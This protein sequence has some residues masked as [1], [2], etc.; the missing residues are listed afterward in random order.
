MQYF[1]WFDSREKNNCVL[2]GLAGEKLSGETYQGMPLAAERKRAYRFLMDDDYPR[3]VKLTDNL[4]NDSCVIVASPRLKEFLL[5]RL[6]AAVEVLKVDI[7][8][9][10]KRVVSKEY[11]IMNLLDLQDCLVIEASRPQYATIGGRKVIVGV[12]DMVLDSKEISQTS[13]LFRLSNCKLPIV[14]REDLVEEIRA[15]KLQG[16]VLSPVKTL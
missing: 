6:G 16:M 8:D 15:Q 9:H 13:Q 1:R 14:A 4:D 12:K 11:S 2:C 3:N 7:L 5:E 10:K